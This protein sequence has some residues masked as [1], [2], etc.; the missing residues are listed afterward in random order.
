[1]LRGG[2]WF[3]DPQRA[4]VAYRYRNEPGDRYGDLGFRLARSIS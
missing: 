3:N 1:V 4:R 2:G